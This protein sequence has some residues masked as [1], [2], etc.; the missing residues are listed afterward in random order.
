MP[1]E[2]SPLIVVLGPT[3]SGKTRLAVQIAAELNGE[4]I[5][6]D[7]RQVYRGM[8]IGTGKDLSEYQVNGVPVPYHLINVADAGERY[9]VFAFQQ[10]CAEAIADIRL[11]GKQPVLCGGTGLYI[12]AL[13]DNFAYTQIPVDVELRAALAQFSH[14][15]LQQRFSHI[16]SSYSERADLSTRKRTIRAIEIGLY[17]QAHPDVPPA[18][19]RDAVIIGLD[20]P[21]DERR[22]RIT[23]RLQQRLDGGLLDEVRNLVKAGL[24]YADL[25]YYGLEYRFAAQFL[26]GETGYEAFVYHLEKA[27]HQFARRQMTWFRRMEKHGKTISWIDARLPIATQQAQA[28]EIIRSRIS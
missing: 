19:K 11:R 12:D 3:A 9:H 15:D 8:D 27:I 22:A 2:T 17:L 5:S 23:A 4:I 25:H 16:K 18:G 20:L 14:S 28:M 26:Q 6:A 24:S 1:P 13:L 7:S 21:A 10:D